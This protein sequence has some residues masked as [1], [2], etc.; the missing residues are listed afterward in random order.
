MRTVLALSL[1]LPFAAQGALAHGGEHGS[2]VLTAG[3]YTAKVKALVCGACAKNI[4]DTA[5]A[6]PGIESVS[7][8]EKSSKLNFTVGPDAHVNVA[9]LQAALKASSEE[10]GMGADYSLRNIRG[11]DSEGSKYKMRVDS[12]THFYRFDANGNPIVAAPENKPG[13]N[14]SRQLARSADAAEQKPAA[15]APEAS[16]EVYVCPMGDYR[17]PKTADGKC[18]KCGMDLLRK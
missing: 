16:Q 15:R 5:R 17:G 9:K 2:K 1:A 14:A 12:Q 6:F 13:R 3:R 4:R 18:P 10:M 8:D 7:V 11:N